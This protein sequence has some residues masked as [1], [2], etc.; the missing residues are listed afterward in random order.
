MLAVGKRLTLRGFIV[1]DHNNLA[2]DF[3]RLAGQW[4][5][6][7][8]LSYQE[9]IVDGIDHAVDAF[10]GLHRGDNTGKMLIRL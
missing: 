5:A 10:L 9:T 6:D 2:P 8:K 7:G 1:S 3:Y 4:I